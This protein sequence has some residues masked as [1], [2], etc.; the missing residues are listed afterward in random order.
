MIV[1]LLLIE[2][3]LIIILIFS[4]KKE[5]YLADYPKYKFCACR[6]IR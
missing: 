3:V 1:Y 2:L 4:N 5:S 6:K